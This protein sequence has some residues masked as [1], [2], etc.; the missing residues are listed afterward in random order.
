MSADPERSGTA[1]VSTPRVPGPARPSDRGSDALV[2]AVYVTIG[3]IVM[4]ILVLAS[5]TTM[6]GSMPGMSH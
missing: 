4:A 1:R 5:Q 6:P 3:L 2:I